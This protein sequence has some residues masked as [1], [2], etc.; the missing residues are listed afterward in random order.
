MERGNFKREFL[1]GN[2]GGL[3]GI[4]TV[5]PLDTAKIRL[6]LYPEYKSVADVFRSMIK[7]D[8][9]STIGL[10]LELFFLFLY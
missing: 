1:G 3:I 2:F 6:Q 9:V 7:N 5:Y 4:I 8:G 10:H